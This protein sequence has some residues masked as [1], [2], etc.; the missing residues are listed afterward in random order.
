MAQPGSADERA[1]LEKQFASLRRRESTVLSCRLSCRPVFLSCLVFADSTALPPPLR[2]TC[3][4]ADGA[5][6]TA[7]FSFDDAA[8]L[9]ACAAAQ[10]TLRTIDA[11]AALTLTPAGVAAAVRPCAAL[12][13][14]SVAFRTKLSAAAS[15]ALSDALPSGCRLECPTEALFALPRPPADPMNP[16]TYTP[17]PPAPERGPHI[18]AAVEAMRAHP[19]SLLVQADGAKELAWLGNGNQ[20]GVAEKNGLE[21]LAAAL[22]THGPRGRAYGEAGPAALASM[23]M[24]AQSNVAATPEAAEQFVNAGGV[25]GALEALRALPDDHFGVATHG[26]GLLASLAGTTGEP[27][28]AALARMAASGAFAAAADAMRRDSTRPAAPRMPS[29]DNCVCVCSMRR[30]PHCHCIAVRVFELVSKAGS[31]G[32]EETA[33]AAREAG[34]D[35][36]IEASFAHQGAN[37]WTPQSLQALRPL[38]AEALASLRRA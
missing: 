6:L 2:R 32:G 21:A 10:Q 29:A 38:A 30:S 22:R 12:T 1:M 3:L 9:E 23:L 14:L 18:A 34:L 28:R 36:A 26:W 15:R 13:G 16:L 7:H 33:R 5:S 25:E 37:G 19:G 17:V 4:S 24:A 8:L 35:A 31:V 27:G 20:T 11:T